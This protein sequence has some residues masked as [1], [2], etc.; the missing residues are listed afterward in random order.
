MFSNVYNDQELI[1]RS[2]IIPEHIILSELL[3]MVTFILQKTH[4]APIHFQFFSLPGQAKDAYGLYQY[5]T[6]RA[7]LLQ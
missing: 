3:I 7:K 1:L 5:A 2:W 4:I 6:I